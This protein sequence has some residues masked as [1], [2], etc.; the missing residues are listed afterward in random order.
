MISHSLN[1]ESTTEVITLN[2]FAIPLIRERTC[3]L[4]FSILKRT[5]GIRQGTH[6]GVL[7]LAYSESHF[8]SYLSFKG[9]VNYLVGIV[10]SLL[11]KQKTNLSI[12]S[13]GPRFESE[14]FGYRGLGLKWR[15]IK[16][17]DTFSYSPK[18]QVGNM[19]SAPFESESFDIIVCGWTIAYSATPEVAFGEFSRL[20]KPGG[21]IVITWDLPDS[22]EVNDPSSLTLNRKQDIDKIET[23]LPESRIF[24]TISTHFSVYRLELGKLTFNSSTPFATL[25]LQPIK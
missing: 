16:G 7:H 23:L 13:I 22:Y 14:L 20:L 17:L 9:R 21:K 4:R 3:R 24:E 5:Y 1:Y 11:P 15:N 2:V 6:E 19:H 25:I 18:I 10:H 8:K 12:L